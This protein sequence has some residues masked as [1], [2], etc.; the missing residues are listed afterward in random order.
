M[1]HNECRG[2]RVEVDEE[3]EVKARSIETAWRYEVRSCVILL[4]ISVLDTRYST[5][6]ERRIC[7]WRMRIV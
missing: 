2:M 5:L 6:Y 4:V 7:Q 3:H 1:K